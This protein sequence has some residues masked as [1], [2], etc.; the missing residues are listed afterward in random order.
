MLEEKVTPLFIL[1]W[2]PE[3]VPPLTP[4]KVMVVPLA[5]AVKLGGVQVDGIVQ[6]EQK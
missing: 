6:S 5:V 1:Y 4:E 2:Y 3:P